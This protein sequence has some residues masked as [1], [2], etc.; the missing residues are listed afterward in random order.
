MTRPVQMLDL[1]LVEIDRPR[2]KQS[3]VAAGNITG[4]KRVDDQ[5]VWIEP[6]SGMVA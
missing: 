2:P 4:V 1:K 3:A 6:I 5:L